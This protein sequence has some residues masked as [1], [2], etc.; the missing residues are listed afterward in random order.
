VLFGLATI[1][2]FHFN[3]EYSVFGLAVPPFA[4]I[5]LQVLLISL[6]VPNASLAGHLAGVMGGLVWAGGG[7]AWLGDYLFWCALGWSWLGFL[8]SVKTTSQFPLPLLAIDGPPPPLIVQGV[9]QRPPR[10]PDDDAV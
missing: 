5:L 3:N 7:F 8:W 6:L 1:S 4:M 2:S 10:A 9:I